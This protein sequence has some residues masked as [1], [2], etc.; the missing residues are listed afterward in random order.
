MSDHRWLLALV[1]VPALIG[2]PDEAS[3]AP[4]G[5]MTWAIHVSLA[6]TWFDPAETPG[7]TNAAGDQGARGSYF[8]GG[9]A[10]GRMWEPPR[11]GFASAWGLTGCWGW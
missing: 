9:A 4:E 6:P 10:G 2:M 8:F 3:A 11:G 5:Q 7:A 1:L